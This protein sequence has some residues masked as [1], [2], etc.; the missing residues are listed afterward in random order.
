[1]IQL[2][3]GRGRGEQRES[4]AYKDDA[5]NN[6]NHTQRDAEN[7]QNERAEEQEEDHQQQRIQAGTARYVETLSLLFALDKS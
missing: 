1:M 2:Y 7:P 4:E 6:P 5:P 3:A